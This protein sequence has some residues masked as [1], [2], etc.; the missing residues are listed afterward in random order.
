MTQINRAPRI[1][2]NN[3]LRQRSAR[4]SA[5]AATLAIAGAT[6]ELENSPQSSDAG[7]TPIKARRMAYYR[8]VSEDP[9]PAVVVIQDVDYPDSVG[10][11]R[12]DRFW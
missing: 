7:C 2:D 3:Y 12:W 9:R 4:R 5:I 6:W 10:A 8:Y 1:L 11:V